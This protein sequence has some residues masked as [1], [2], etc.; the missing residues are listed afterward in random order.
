MKMGNNRKRFSKIKGHLLTETARHGKLEIEDANFRA[1]CVS[2][3]NG[4][5][6]TANELYRGFSSMV[7]QLKEDR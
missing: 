5:T 7:K 2:L 1:M 4:T 3:Y 6:I